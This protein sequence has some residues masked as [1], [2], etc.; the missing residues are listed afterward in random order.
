MWVSL[1]KQCNISKPRVSS[2]LQAKEGRFTAQ[3]ITGACSYDFAHESS[4]QWTDILYS[5][6]AY[7][8]VWD[9]HFI[10]S[11]ANAFLTEVPE[12]MHA[13]T[14]SY[15]HNKCSGSYTH[16]FNIIIFSTTPGL[17]WKQCHMRL[18]II[19]CAKI[20]LIKKME[21]EQRWSD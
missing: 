18:Q 4:V 20:E 21:L 12:T 9:N 1:N 2:R 14:V 11:V 10:P 3:H 7:D 6:I 19:V 8:H 5:C 17:M 16:T 13:T 15:N